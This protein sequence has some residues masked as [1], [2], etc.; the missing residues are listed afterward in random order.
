MIS[1]QLTNPSLSFYNRCHILKTDVQNTGIRHELTLENAFCKNLSTVGSGMNK[2]IWP[3]ASVDLADRQNSIKAHLIFSLNT[4]PVKSR[5]DFLPI[6]SRYCYLCLF[7]QHPPGKTG[8]N[9]SLLSPPPLRRFMPPFFRVK[10]VGVFIESIHWG[11]VQ[12]SPW[13]VMTM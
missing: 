2:L 6:L 11:N 3:D 8:P 4:E 5:I 1:S 13:K 7:F 10:M 12:G 9:T